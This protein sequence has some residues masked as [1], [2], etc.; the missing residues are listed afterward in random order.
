MVGV[1]IL[2]SDFI[3]FVH[4]MSKEGIV[5]LIYCASEEQLADLMTKPLKLG[6]FMKLRNSL[7][8]CSEIEVNCKP[9]AAV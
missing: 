8:V 4:E 6:V 9:E 7:G 2:M 5:D 1:N 3:S